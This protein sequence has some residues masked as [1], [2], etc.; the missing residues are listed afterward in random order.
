MESLVYLLVAIFFLLFSTLVSKFNKTITDTMNET[1]KILLYYNLFGTYLSWLMIRLLLTR[2]L[3]DW[4]FGLE[5][6]S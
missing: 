1:V 6:L 2:L 3:G 5:S 4:R